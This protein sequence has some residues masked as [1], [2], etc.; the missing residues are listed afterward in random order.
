MFMASHASTSFETIPARMGRPLVSEERGNATMAAVTGPVFGYSGP[1]AESDGARRR[2]WW[3]GG[4]VAVWVLV[5]GGLAFWSADTGPPT[6]P[7]Q[8]DI[9]QAVPELEKAAGV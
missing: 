9:S 2:R 3:L 1:P 4:L 8:R 6:V 7:E 5:L